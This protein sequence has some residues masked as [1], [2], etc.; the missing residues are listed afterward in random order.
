[1]ANGIELA[2]AY[3][4]IVPSAEGIQGSISH[5][6]GGEASSA[7]ESA[8]TLLGTKLVGTLKK[9]IAA[10]GIGKMISDSL[11]LGG[12]LQQSIGGVETLFKE[13]AD[14]VKTYAAQAYRTVGLSANDY[15]EQTTSF[16][17]SLLSSVSKDTNAAAQLANM[18]MVDM[19]DNANKMGTDMASIQ[20]AYQ[21]FAKQNYT[22]LDNLKLGYGGTQAEMQRLLTDAEKLSGVHYE[23]GNLADMYSAI[24]I[25]QTDLDITGTTAKE[26]ATTLTGS[27]AAMKAAAQNVLGDWSTGADLTAPMQA[28]ADT[29]RTFLQGNLLPMIGNVLAG[30]PQLVYG[31]V[32]EVLQTGTELVSSLAAGFA[33]GIPAFLSTALPQLLSFTE[34]LRANAG[35]F[36]DAGL[37]CIT[38]LLN[39]L[40]AGLPQ[41]IAYVPDI[42]INIAGIINDN[43]PK[44]LAQGVSIIVQLIAGII[45][46]VPALLANWKKILQA[47][48]SVISAINWLN[49]GKNILT[50]VANGVKSMGS[51][52]LTAFKG[53]F[54]SALSWIKSLPS[55]AVKWG[56]NLIQSFIKGLTGKGNVVSNAATAVT[57]GI[58]LAET[59]SGKQD[60]WAASWASSN[61]SLGS[62]AQT[63]AEIAIPA[64]TKSGD[65]AVAS[66]SKA[67]AAA[68]KTATA[69]SVVSSYADTVTEVL[70]KITRTTQTTDEVLSNGQKQQK[71][72]ITETSRQLV[73][74]VLK[75]IKTITTIGANGK[76]TVQQ[77]MET[78]RELASSVTST[79]EA[80]VDGIRTA[81]Q[82]V[83]ETLTDGTESQKQTITK[84]YTA[85]I[86]GALRTVKEVKTIAADGT[87]QVAKTL[88]EASSKNFSGLVQG[89]KKEADKGVLGTFNT[90]ISAVKSKDWK[91]IGQWVLSTLYNGL[92]PESQKFIDDFGQNLIQQLNKVLGDKISNIS[93]KAWDIGSSIA[94]GIAKGLGNALG[95]DGG[96]QDILNGLNINVSDVG[97]KIMGVLGTIGTSMGTFA[98]EAGAKIAGLA[99]SMGSLGTIAEGVGGLIAK[100]G[101]LIISNPEVAAIIAIVAGVVALGVAL[102]AKFGKSKE[103]TSTQKAHSYKDIQDAYWYGN[104]R[105]FAGYD[106]RTDPYV[107]NPDNNAM[108]AYQAK[109]QAQMERLYGVVE[110]YLPEAGNSVIALDGEQVGR[111]ITPSVNRSLGDLT[112]LSERGN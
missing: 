5:I 4:Q 83:T 13:S 46:A 107:M 47:V 109:M 42:I 25:I 77:T 74:G 105:A 55:Q 64:Y 20:N 108:L 40:I 27:F 81:T 84:T 16:A 82:T 80:L 70:G 88:E 94:D 24:H 2:K 85:I 48:L 106:Y 98:T 14:T 54:S 8:G 112:V 10:A 68:S 43:M 78:V 62:S 111:I 66:A 15:M 32:P 3:V 56:K 60:N 18:A 41:L 9:V 63:M 45:Q 100:V 102:F 39:G 59:A 17:A 12:A 86:D 11:N 28:L 7:G 22:M 52:M 38:Q 93:Q 26:A 6:M 44:I 58:S 71:Q 110:K 61:T 33:Q 95:K 73:N 1:M 35:Q 104:E 67:A 75:D 87:E 49:I 21:G 50:S 90:L 79:S 31:L 96:V 51:S 65:A 29:A 92:A 34:E 99:G 19:A 101:G 53:G 37:N 30:I 97:S 69:A 23:L 91:S 57:A 76:K 36:V 89:W 72:T 103:T